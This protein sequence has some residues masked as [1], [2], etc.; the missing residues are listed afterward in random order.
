MEYTTPAEVEMWFEQLQ[1]LEDNKKCTAPE[2]IK[3]FHLATLAHRI[4]LQKLA[5]LGLP[6]KIAP[7]QTQ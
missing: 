6:E 5:K 3:P 1:H 4:H 2:F 7:T